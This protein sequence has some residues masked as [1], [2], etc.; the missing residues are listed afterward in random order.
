[1]VEGQEEDNGR[2]AWHRE[3]RQRI[4][5][6]RQNATVMERWGKCHASGVM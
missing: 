4:K 2:M 5:E 1:M 3:E 6:W